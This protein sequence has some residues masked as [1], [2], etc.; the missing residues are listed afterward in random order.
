MN[1]FPSIGAVEVF[2]RTEATFTFEPRQKG[3]VKVAEVKTPTKEAGVDFGGAVPPLA[4][5][6]PASTHPY[7]LIT[8]H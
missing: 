3:T 5:C 2:S 4:T 1:I 7:R 6:S 8:P